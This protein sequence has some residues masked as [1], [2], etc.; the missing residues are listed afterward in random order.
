V[1]R[2]T[3]IEAVSRQALAAFIAHLNEKLGRDARL[4]NTVLGNG[5]ELL[6]LI[7]K[8]AKDIILLKIRQKFVFVTSVCKL[9]FRMPRKY[10]F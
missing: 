7:L 6:C 2:E 8:F 4:E 3:L 5:T 10:L 9:K 1:N